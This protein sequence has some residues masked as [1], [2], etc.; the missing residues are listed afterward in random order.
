MA[1]HLKWC[2]PSQALSWEFETAGANH[3]YILKIQ[4]CNTT[5]SSKIAKISGC[6][7]LLSKNFAG[8]RHP[9][10]PC[11]LKP[12]CTMECS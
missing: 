1:N 10:H 8:A 5:L 9:W 4:G 7:T 12:C 11:L 2:Y 3:Y 6:K